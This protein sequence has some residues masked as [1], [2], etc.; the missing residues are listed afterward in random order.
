MG[1]VGKGSRCKTLRARAPSANAGIQA[2]FFLMQAFLAFVFYSCFFVPELPGNFFFTIFHL[3]VRLRGICAKMR[4]RQQVLALLA[5]LV[6]KAQ[7]KRQQ[8]LSLLALLVQRHK[9]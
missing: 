5:L 9:Y 6:Q 1:A 7:R 3:Q 2:V 8:V 4:K